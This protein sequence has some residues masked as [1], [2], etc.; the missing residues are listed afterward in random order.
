MDASLF[1][2]PTGPNFYAGQKQLVE[3]RNEPRHTSRPAE[4]ARFP[5]WAAPFSD[6]RLVTDYRPHCE[7]NIPVEAQEKTRI[8]LQRNT[9]SIILMS[10]QR[11]SEATGAI[12][13]MDTSLEPP[14][15]MVVKCT[16]AGCQRFG[17]QEVHGIGVERADTPCPDLFMSWKPDSI[18]SA[19]CPRV[20]ITS[21]E[22]G[23]RNTRRG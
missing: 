17:T 10:R 8:W 20:G 21:K 1:R 4:D 12:Y 7:V 13:G 15:A 2:L 5:G 19:P 6:G 16:T 22:E 18:L 9:D 14:S 11:A 23:G 3:L